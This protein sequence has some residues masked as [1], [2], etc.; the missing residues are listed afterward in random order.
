ML[1]TISRLFGSKND[2]EIKK[3][4]PLVRAV[5]DFEPKL[6]ALDDAHLQAKTGEF[7]QRLAQGATLDD[8][9]PEAFAA[10]REASRRVLG[11]RHFDVQIM[12]GI[13]LHRGAIAEMKTGEGKTLT[14]TLPL[15]LNALEGRGAWLVTVND[16]LAK[17]DAEWM[18]QIYN[19][20]GLSVGVILH[21]KNDRER[22]EAYHS[23]I[24]YGTNN[25]FGFDYLR[26]N[27]KFETGTLVQ[28]DYRY[29]IVDEVD[30]VLIDE[31][32]TPLIISGA[33]DDNT[34]KYA[35]A[36][37]VVIKLQSGTHYT[38]D[39]KDHHALFTEEGIQRSEKLLGVS[40]LYDAAN[41]EILHC[42]EQSLK[43]QFL[44]KRDVDYMINDG[45]VV[46]VDQHT[47][48][49]MP[50][51]RYSDG[52]HQ[53]L[54]AKEGVTIERQNQTLASVTFQNFFRMFD[55]LSGMTGT[56]ET[57]APE[58]LKIYKLECFVLPTN[59]PMAR[60]D[61]NDL[62]YGNKVAKF[63]A[64]VE[65][66]RKQH[67]NGRP[68]LVGT[69]AIETSEELSSVLTRHGIKHT[70]LNAKYHAIEADIIAQAG[71]LGGVTI[72]T[73]MAGRGTDIILGGNPEALARYDQ[74][75]NPEADFDALY[76]KYKTICDEEKKRV[77]ELGGLF[78]LG[79]ERHESRRIDNQLRGRSGRQGDPGRSQFY[80]ALDDKLMRLFGNQT[81]KN[82]IARNM[83]EDEPIEHKIISRSVE[84]AQ[85]SIEARNFD[86]RKHLLEYD[87]VM[88][89]QRNTFYRMRR[90]LLFGNSGRDFLYERV[91]D[92]ANHYVNQYND[93]ER[94]DESE[95][96]YLLET[97]FSIFAYEPSDEI[98]S[99]WPVDTKAVLAELLTEVKA[100]YEDK[101]NLLGIPEDVVAHQERFIMLYRIDQQWK[102]HMRN[103]DHLKEGIGLMS[104]AQK[105]PLI[106]YKKAS[107]EMFTDL[108]YRIDEDVV[109][110]LVHLRPTLSE[111]SMRVMQR[112]RAEEAK[113]MRE[114]GTEVEEQRTK[115]VRRDRPKLGRNDP[116]DCGSGKKYKHCHGKA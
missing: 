79:T 4:Q 60:V 8:L 100:D 114:V 99:A 102:D 29:A 86:S 83:E 33:A 72:A 90:E 74:R 24:T 55:K 34:Q 106:E 103:M 94:P 36:N 104:Y 44:F 58:F 17:R 67:Q 75:Q 70:V 40:N 30:S 25:E 50:G 68:I 3:L 89:Q 27:M 15:Y 35:E 73:N 92:I 51:R 56:A 43:A 5:A 110:T 95:K 69:I 41:I 109:K 61:A 112:R 108:L 111:D 38:V 53:A 1:A 23:D 113:A 66:I 14:A 87:D 10:T 45:Q 21:D 63:K 48:R 20:L 116:C 2:R 19:F 101:W 13:I 52:L 42:L 96:K 9:L 98:R 54:E 71:R 97:F 59:K 11:M 32:R 105:D 39:E 91:E 12:G 47:G 16:Y 77:L 115:T 57:E 31:A 78:I 46:I 65:E 28:R 64:I 37:E 88:N 84:K 85:K 18:G 22:Y 49:L 62:I 80:L 76:A 81:I 93:N 82:Y 6:K 7:K 107:L 26:D